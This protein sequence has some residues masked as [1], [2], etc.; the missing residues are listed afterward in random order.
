MSDEFLRVAKKE[1]SGDIAEIGI[2]LQSCYD[3]DALC[4]N[5]IQLEKYIHKIKGLAPMMGSDQIG[6]V[7][8]LIDNLLKTVLT[9]GSVKGICLATKKSYEFMQ[10]AMVGVDQDLD[11]LKAEIEKIT[12]VS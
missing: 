6:D 1:L 2:L 11:H 12:T 9:G 7:A 3:D 10:N 5:A 4:K 8:V